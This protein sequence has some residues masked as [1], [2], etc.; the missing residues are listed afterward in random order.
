MRCFYNFILNGFSNTYLIGPDEGGDA[1]LVDPGELNIK[2]FNLIEDNDFYIRHILI[3]HNDNPHTEGIKTI[4][5]IYDASIY[6]NSSRIGNIDTV[7]VTEGSEFTISGF[8]VK[9]VKAPDLLT[10]S[11]LYKIDNMLF[12]GDI[13]G[14]GRISKKLKNLP[15]EDIAGYI[16]NN[17]LCLD[18]NTLV[19]PGHGPPSTMKVE[20]MFNPDI[21]EIL[22]NP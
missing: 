6:C 1:I 18:D 21:K 5:K 13:L 14:A 9:A 4:L 12:T 16:R 22:D 11:I 3:T 20:R 17:L 19:F 2:L 7:K 8:R 15:K 10:D